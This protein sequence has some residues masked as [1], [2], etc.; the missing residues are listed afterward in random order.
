ML[1]AS[2]AGAQND[3]DVLLEAGL[4]DANILVEGY[5]APVMNG[6]GAGLS[7]GWY[8]TAKAHKTAGFDLTVTVNAAFI[9]DDDLF[10]SPQFFNT[11]YAPGSPTQSPTVA[12]PDDPG[13]IPTYEY[14]FEEN[15]QTFTGTFQGPEGAA[16]KDNIGLQAIPVP[17]AQLGIGIIK[18][19][20]I[21]IRWT[22][23]IDIGNDGE[24]KL[25]GFAIMHD[26][27]QHIPG[28]KNLP[29]DLSFLA[30]F[31]DISLEYDLAIEGSSAG[32]GEVR[33]NNGVGQFDVNAW[34]FQGVISKKFSVLT[35][36]GGLG[37][38]IIKSNIG[39]NG[40]Y[41]IL[42][43]IADPLTGQ[44]I[45]ER[46]LVN[47]IGLDFNQNGARLTAGFRLKLAILTLH[48]DYTFQKYNTLSAGVGFSIR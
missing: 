12:G 36:Y 17:M 16:F 44:P 38:N 13:S 4:D 29:F 34:T 35:L 3:L 20:D 45:V 6:L 22:P 27:K 47:P 37:Y 33:T 7:N 9:P 32:V 14:S 39:L 8:N 18:N 40:N 24:F 23:T 42:S 28:M 41:E 15:G 1:P 21:K 11:Q 48:T 19:T 26:I 30:G 31:T 5:I 46:V 2:I 25:L 43:D 10:Y